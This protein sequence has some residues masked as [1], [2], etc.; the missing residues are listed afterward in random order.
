MF[1][2]ENMRVVNVRMNFIWTMWK[3][4][5][6]PQKWL[7]KQ[8][9]T[10]QIDFYLTFLRS[11]NSNIKHKNITKFSHKYLNFTGKFRWKTSHLLYINNIPNSVWITEDFKTLSN[12]SKCAMKSFPTWTSWLNLFDNKCLILKTCV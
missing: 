6:F 8:K 9:N 1:E 5:Y 7:S 2:S 10:K 4:T 3:L 11:S 12:N